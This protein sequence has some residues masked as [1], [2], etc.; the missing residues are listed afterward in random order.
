V[1]DPLIKKS[2]HLV[3]AVIELPDV[4]EFVDEVPLSLLLTVDALKSGQK[5]WV[6]K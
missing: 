3:D 5:I 6:E 4:H 1:T 2:E